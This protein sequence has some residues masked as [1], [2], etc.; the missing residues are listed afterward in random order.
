M[1]EKTAIIIP[2]FN[3]EERIS[4]E[5]YIS[6]LKTMHRVDFFFI[7]D[8]SKDKTLQ[9]LKDIVSKCS[10]STLVTNSTNLGKGETI[11]FGLIEI[12][13]LN[14][15]EF[16]G[17]YD[18][19]M[20]TPIDEINA[21]LNLPNKSKY[22]LILCSRIQRLG[23]LI[24]RK[25]YRHY[26]GRVFATAASMIL[27]LPVY[28]TQCGAKLIHKSVVPVVTRETFTSKW[29]FDI[30]IIFRILKAGHGETDF[31]EHPVSKWEDV[32]GSKLKLFDFLKAPLELLKIWL[33]YR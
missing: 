6:L 10:N 24:N 22:K 30:E 15:Y 9:I 13:K 16:L 20:A 12:S 7:D 27:G 1:T 14:R 23:S 19:D 3:E 32:G 5:S 31:F 2:C 4:S 8:G 28:D 26:I 11:R 29:L 25:P 18:C 21:M 33:R 17:F